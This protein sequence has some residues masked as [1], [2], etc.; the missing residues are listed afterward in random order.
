MCCAVLCLQLFDVV[1]GSSYLR[2]TT[3]TMLAGHNGR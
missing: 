2:N 1:E 3:Y